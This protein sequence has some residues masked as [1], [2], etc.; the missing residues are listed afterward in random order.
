MSTAAQDQNIP[1]HLRGNYAPVSE[2][3]S[4]FD[5]PVQGEIPRRLRA[6]ST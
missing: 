4:A 1:F 3:V 5:L 6:P 2:E